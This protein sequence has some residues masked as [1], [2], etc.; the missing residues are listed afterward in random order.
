MTT[1]IDPQLTPAEPAERT[2][3]DYAFFSTQFEELLK[4]WN[5]EFLQT[6]VRRT[7]RYIDIDVKKMRS[8]GVIK[9]DEII[10]P[11]RVADKNIRR[12]QPS[13][14]AFLTQ[15]RRSL[16]FREKNGQWDRAVKHEEALESEFTEGMRYPEWEIPM[17]KATDGAQTHGWDSV[18]V[19][20]DETKPL[21]V[22]VEQVG[23]DKLLFSVECLDIQ[24]AT[25]VCR[26]YDLSAAQL[27]KFVQTFDFDA[28][29]VEQ[30][31]SADKDSARAGL[32]N[33]RVWKCFFRENG[34]VYVA[35]RCDS[36]SVIGSTSSCNDWLKKPMKLY[37][38]RQRMEMVTEMQPVQQVNMITGMPEMLMTPVQ[39]ETVV[40]EDE[41]QYPIYL[42]R[43]HET[44]NQQIF[45]T[46]GRVFMDQYAQ[47]AQTAIASGFI[48]GLMRASNVYAAVK[49][50]LQ[51]GSSAPPKQLPVKLQHGGMY[52]K[53]VDFF[54]SE[55]P[56]P[57]VLSAL[58]WFNTSNADENGQVDF[59]V[60]NRKDS[61]KTATEIQAA[62]QQAGLLSG[63]QV[64][65]YSAWVC[66]VYTRCWT[67]VQSLAMM[68]K[69]E[70]LQILN[71][72]TGVMENN[73]DV[74]GR[75]YYTK[76]AGDVDVVQR[77]ERV[78]KMQE[79]WP[80]ISQTAAAPQF[81]RS[82]LQTAFPEGG[83][84]WAAT[85]QEDQQVKQLLGVCAQMLQSLVASR[86]E[87]FTALPPEQKQQL[88]ALQQQVQ[89][90]LNPQQA[91]ASV[92]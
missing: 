46:K 60:N 54:H 79:F 84:Q 21:K 2:Y 83:D 15:S 11:Q 4:D 44:E 49:S 9:D 22:G 3:S 75:K 41:V 12:E 47:E 7:L 51:Q 63:V 70:F 1:V 68:D 18:E 20:Y 78:R 71:P 91:E 52:D 23:H 65:L 39:V 19:V 26:G 27:K 38:G 53:P 81:L 88:M 92:Q 43:Y 6:R 10:T 30:L 69:I 50:D 67:V 36:S 34:V 45:T 48:N 29:Q 37:L 5:G 13:Y 40:D 59:A 35:W 17:F 56:N 32:K 58:Q 76:A 85:I 87:E 25:Y 57:V 24:L 55:Y 74:I 90:V 77:A 80:V 64:T 62:S 61:R 8:A 82:M 66:S 72:D 28:V 86:P 42:L 89:M 16:I 73:K 31:I 14:I 33:Y